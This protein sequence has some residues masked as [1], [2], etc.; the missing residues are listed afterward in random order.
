MSF[1]RVGF[2][3]PG[4]V[5][6]PVNSDMIAETVNTILA[7]KLKASDLQSKNMSM[8]IK[9][10]TTS[11]ETHGEGM[12]SVE[13]ELDR[14]QEELTNCK[15][16]TDENT[17][18]RE[19]VS[20]MKHAMTRM[21]TMLEELQAREIA[22][23]DTH[24]SVHTHGS[25]HTDIDSIVPRMINLRLTHEKAKVPTC[26]GDNCLREDTRLRK[27]PM[28]TTMNSDV[29]SGNAGY[30]FY[31]VDDIIIPPGAVVAVNT[32]VQIETPNNYYL[33]LFSRSGNAKNKGL[34]VV[35]GV[36]D[37]PYRGDIKALI[38]N[39]TSTEKKIE[40]SDRICQGIFLPILSVN[41]R[42]CDELSNTTRGADGFGS[43]G[44]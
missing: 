44:N 12:E 35:G 25:I 33:Q 17:K 24:G 11:I 30:D 9:R 39:S 4:Q 6:T 41:F 40:K 1:D 42:I 7:D 14:I 34:H 38:L 36:V 13:K 31:S 22:S 18:L 21:Q 23:A 20:E 26:G 27:V 37:A 19:T 32:H 15:V 5:A 29:H 3:I 2:Q 16:I 10:L 8:Q 43:T 28:L